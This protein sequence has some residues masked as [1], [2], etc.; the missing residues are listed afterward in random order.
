MR[1]K[2]I[3]DDIWEEIVNIY[4]DDSKKLNIREW[5]ESENPHAFQEMTEI[6]LE[7][8]RKGYWEADEATR[9]K[10][11]KEYA[12]SVA[13]HG[14]GGGILGGGN[15]KLEKFVEKTLEAPGSKDLKDLLYFVM[16]IVA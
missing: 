15:T 2:S 4:V 14:E 12:Q 3:S 10:I 6:L 1:E 7:S 5:F 13:R 9:L 11:A 8:I 16:M